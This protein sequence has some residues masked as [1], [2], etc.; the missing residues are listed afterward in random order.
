MHF[1]CM[2]DR[3][4]CKVP[5]DDNVADPLTKPLPHSKH[6]RHIRS[7]GIRYDVDWA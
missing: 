3:K 7:M 2:V 4:I 6:E 5:I 1:Y